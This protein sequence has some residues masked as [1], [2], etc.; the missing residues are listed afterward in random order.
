MTYDDVAP[1][2][3]KTEALIGVFGS[4]EGLENTPDGIFQPPQA[5]CL[6]TAHEES[7]RQTGNPGHSIPSG[8]PDEP[9]ERK[10]SL[11]LR[12]RLRTRLFDQSHFQSTTV[13]LPPAIQ[14]GNL[15]SSRTRWCGGHHRQCWK[16]TGVN[17]IDKATRSDMHAAASGNFAASGC[18]SARILLNS[19]SNLFQN[20]L[21]NGSGKVGRYLMDTVGSDLNGQIPR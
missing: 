13:L 8:D 5:A 9:Y 10:T 14:T 11:L 7:L 16:A 18:E 1:Y 2:Y 17:Y 12:H 15:T 4:K 20:G 6:R 19:K 3:D 21:A